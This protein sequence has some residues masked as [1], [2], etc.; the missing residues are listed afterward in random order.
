MAHLSRCQIGEEVHYS[1]WP[2]PVPPFNP[3]QLPN[4]HIINVPATWGEFADVHDTARPFLS[5]YSATTVNGRQIYRH[6]CS[7]GLTP[8][9]ETLFEPFPGIDRGFSLRS[10]GW[11]FTITK[12]GL[13]SHVGPF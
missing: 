1:P 2:W 7:C 12:S 4:P 8:G 6:D 9:W 3:N 13:S 10:D 5:P 11:W